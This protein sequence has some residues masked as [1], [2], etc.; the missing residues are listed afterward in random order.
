[1]V[2]Y[3]RSVVVRDVAVTFPAGLV[4][5][6][7]GRNG[8][9]KSSLLWALTGVIP[10]AG[11][12]A[13]DGQPLEHLSPD[14]ARRFIRMVP[15]NASDLLYLPSVGQECAAADRD[16]G[17]QPGLCRWL[18][19]TLA[20]GID[21]ATHPRDLSEGQK[22]CLVLGIQLTA[23]PR[24]VVL[25]EP[26]RGLDYPAKAALAR[27]LVDLAG[28]GRAVAVVTHDVEFAAA[29]ADRIIVMATGDVIQT[30]VASE[31][32][33]TSALF[34]SQVAKVLYPDRWLTAYQVAQALTTIRGDGTTA[35]TP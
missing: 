8:S 14:Q 30:G 1:M 22:L 31:V 25:D 3:G 15:Q 10:S 19:E 27:I 24:V 33:G 35:D 11:A 29:V 5:V 12:V 9:G 6:I 32:L 34:A 17:S 16:N 28:A 20:P 23:R 2:A 26:T 13:V 18:V 21:P 7:M 4:T